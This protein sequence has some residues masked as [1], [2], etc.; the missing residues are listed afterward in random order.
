MVFLGTVAF[1]I[2]QPGRVTPAVAATVGAVL[3]LVLGVVP[4]QDVLTVWNATWNA[5]L[6]LVGLIL[7]SLLL[8]EAGFFRWLALHVARWGGGRG[9]RLFV[10][11]I[12]FSAVVT[13]LYANDGG[14]LILTPIV[15]ELARALRLERAAT[16]AFALAVGFV[17]DVSSLPLTVSNLVNIVVADAFGIGFAPYA[18]VMLPVNVAT[19]AATLLALWWLYARVVPR[20]YDVQALP[21]PASALRSRGTARLGAALLP[22]LLVGYFLAEP[23]HVPLCVVTLSAAGALWVAAGRSRALSSRAV[24]RSAPWD[25]V[26]FSLGMYLVVYGLR[27]A[28]FTALFSRWVE[29]GAAHGTGALVFGVGGAVAVLSAFMNNLP[30]VLF[31][32]LGIQGAHVPEAARSLA[33]FAA[34]VGADVG[35]KLTPVGSLATLLWLHV[36]A[37]R[38]VRVSWAEYFRVGL[39]L[40]PPVLLVALRALAWGHA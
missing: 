21:L 14:V 5:T 3:A 36:L 39:V 28:H 18:R 19:V 16:V 10:L 29:W 13:A 35:P 11:L 17:V 25:V 7:V 4:V 37:R 12:L 2:W 26:V 9:A 8:D 15:L 1:V 6:T 40:T 38:D 31:G 33:A 20:R 27:E 34:V 32:V 24:V 23:L 30:A 22:V